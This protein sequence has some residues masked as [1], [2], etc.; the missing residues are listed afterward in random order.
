MIAKRKR[1]SGNFHCSALRLLKSIFAGGLKEFHDAEEQRKIIM[2][3]VISYIGVINLLLLGYSAYRNDNIALGFFDHFVAFV[4]LFLI[5]YLRRT[6]NHLFVS[7]VGTSVVGMLFFYLFTS[8]GV[9]NTGHLW[10]YTFPLI[11]CVRGGGLKGRI[12]SSIRL[13]AAALIYFDSASCQI[14]TL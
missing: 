13:F 14:H 3:N 7:L 2:I 8:R 11:S 1:V 5:I 10:Y 6:G 9:N 12:L 4:L